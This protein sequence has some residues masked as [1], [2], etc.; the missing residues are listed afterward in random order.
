MKCIRNFLYRISYTISP[1]HTY[2]MH[3]N[4]QPKHNVHIY[5][6]FHCLKCGTKPFPCKTDNSPKVFTS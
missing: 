6:E 3:N 4:V 2:S 1:P 5:V